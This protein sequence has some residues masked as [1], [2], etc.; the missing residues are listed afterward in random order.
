MKTTDEFISI[1][2]SSLTRDLLVW[3][4][5]APR[6]YS[7]TMDAWRSTCPQLAIWEDALADGLVRV[8]ANKGTAQSPSTVVLT[9]RG[10]AAINDDAFPSVYYPHDKREPS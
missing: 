9:T 8:E 6:T 4:E 10:R 5:H 1:G 2:I 3:I 7:E